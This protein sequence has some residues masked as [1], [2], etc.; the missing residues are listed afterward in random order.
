[1]A[2]T[3]GYAS[4]PTL[5]V[6]DAM[7]QIFRAFYAVPAHFS[8]TNQKGETEHTNA[9]YGFVNL[10]L[11]VVSQVQ[12]EYITVAFD[13]PAPTFRD[14]AFPDYKANREAPPDEL[15][16]QFDRVR[17]VVTALGLPRYEL[18]GFEADDILGFMA[19]DGVEQGLRVL[20][21]TGDRDAFQLINENVG[22][23]T[24]NPRTGEP[25]IYDTEKV[26]QR[27]SGLVPSQIVDLKALQG[28]SSDNIPGVPGIGEKTALTLLN[29]YGDLDTILA[30]VD[31][32]T[33]RAR[34]ALESPENQAL[35]RLSRKLATIVTDLPLELDLDKARVW[36]PDLERT[37][38]LFAELQFRSLEKRLPFPL[39]TDETAVGGAAGDRQL[40]LFAGDSSDRPAVQTVVDQKSARRLLKALQATEATGDTEAAGASGA[41]DATAATGLFPVVKDT[42]EGPVLAGL[43]LAPDPNS[44]WY[45]P[46]ITTDGDVDPGLLSLFADWL[47]D[48]AATKITYHAKELLRSLQPLALD[49]AGIEFDAGIGAYL[50]GGAARLNT[51]DDIVL[52]RL[53]VQL[54]PP[55]SEWPRGLGLPGL[56]PDVLAAAAA[57]RAATLLPV[58]T[59]LRAD[60][61]DRGLDDLLHDIE[62]P[63]IP[64]LAR[65]E[66]HGVKLDSELL[67]KTSAQLAS[68]LDTLRAAI[69]KD[70]GREFSINSP[71][72]LGAILFEELELPP[73]PKTPGGQFSTSRQVLEDRL[74]AHP[75][76]GRVLEYRELDKL[77]GT[78]V[79]A[80][81][82]LVNP[83]TGRLHTTFSQTVAATGRLSSNNPN[84]Q[85]IPVR[86]ERGQLIRKA[87]VAEQKGHVL[88]AADYSQ[89]ELRVLAHISEDQSM[90]QAFLND[91]DIHTA[92]A[93]QMFAV[94]AA[95]VTP[96]QRRV[97]KT[98]NFGIIY[99]ITGH[100][101]AARTDLSQADAAELIASYFKQYPVIRT[102]MD[103][104]IKSAHSHGY[105]STLLGRRRYL[106]ELRARSRTQRQAGERMAIN[107]PIQ[108][109]AADIMKIAMIHMDRRLRES[110]LPARMILQVHDEL[111]FELPESDVPAVAAIT[112]EIMEGAYQLAIPLKVDLSAGPTWADLS[113]V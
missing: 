16:P 51:L 19:R 27:W 83:R 21:V 96:A 32:L 2:K 34:K 100:G 69:H 24:T 18:P 66:E 110:G 4:R 9:V 46:V 61:S 113:P 68:E 89:I 20:L 30:S 88:L 79:D 97:A 73:G 108:G 70:A 39:D 23:V 74:D 48:P 65:V 99:G 98:T 81:P 8:I 80:L 53:Q 105:A 77:K 92:T 107:M 62:M 95:A 67:K 87:F 93:A 11:R 6:I 37:R 57:D 41:I 71:K 55:A 17:Q 14:D 35:A 29:E 94:A 45:L 49:A 102:Y 91:E 12:P 60:L 101:L 85:N 31:S 40:G 106:P 15:I 50:L 109:T 103:D 10:L 13:T 3:D 5:V 38:E 84:L 52:N 104:T 63:L 86:T 44:R 111:L 36:Q 25:V 7:S 75:I 90:I 78:Y 54:E 72:Q 47:A 28:D 59:D 26:A 112:R 76:I 22:V 58:A 43:G 33:G 42:A 56:E 82:A 64:V 1:M